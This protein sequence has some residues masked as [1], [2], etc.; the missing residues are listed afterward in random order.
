MEAALSALP[1]GLP[2][3]YVRIM[4]RIEAQSPY[5]R[6]LALNCL[7]WTIYA[8]RPLS[9]V[10]L[11]EALA[12]NSNCESI[13][14]LQ[15]DSPQVILEACCNLLQETNGS[16][17][18]IHY[19][20]QEF[21]TR[22]VQGL[23]QKTMQTLLQERK[24]MHR[25]IGLGCLVYARLVAFEKPVEE[26]VSLRRRL[27]AYPLVAY[28]CQNFDYHV[29]QC[30]EPGQ[31]IFD[32]LESLFRQDSA[33]LAAILQI[34][35]WLNGYTHRAMLGRFNRMDFVVTP[36]TIIYSTFLY[37]IPTMKQ[38]CLGQPPPTYALQ[39]AASTGLA[40]GV[41][42][43]L[44]AG[45]PAN[46]KDNIGKTALYYA[47]LNGYAEIVEALFDNGADVNAEDDD[48]GSA[49]QLAS[50]QGHGHIVELLLEKG[51]N[52]NIQGGGCIDALQ[53]ASG[54]GYAQIVEML[55]KKG[56]DVNAPGEHYGTALQLASRGGYD[57]IVR[58][59]INEGAD[60]NAPGL[61][62]GNALH[63]ASYAGHEQIVKML[64][65][66]GAD[67]N[68]QDGGRNALEVASR[69][70]HERIV[71]ILLDNGANVN[72]QAENFN[73]L[74][75]ASSRRHEQRIVQMRLD[76]GAYQSQEDRVSA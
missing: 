56:A 70:G 44:Q 14:H 13:Q 22:T 3:T 38:K 47:C 8:R 25:I 9:T 21:L 75:A 4:E 12:V 61:R 65:E 35:V 5:M 34:K 42:G 60:V 30:G 23:P 31:D 24:S 50:R 19:T 63:L 20:V 62:F 71:K 36:S 58:M 32:E 45:C 28:A 67:V 43:L 49:L 64:L 33:Y 66:K 59:L 46:G 48:Y 40:S 68:A 69:E 41:I 54:T 26:G 74:Q 16:I 15:P 57:H 53:Q 6:E 52:V 76:A 1:Q 39:L 17:R 2:G 37:C 7:V 10:E 72:T 11:Q 29:F 73:A 51:V 18:P 55:I 27:H